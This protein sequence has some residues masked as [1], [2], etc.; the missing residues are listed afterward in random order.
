MEPINNSD[1]AWLIISDYNQDNDL[2]YEELRNDI[3]SPDVND[4]CY[5][6]RSNGVG[7]DVAEVGSYME[8]SLRVG[9]GLFFLDRRSINI[10]EVGGGNDRVG[11]SSIIRGLEVGGNYD[12]SN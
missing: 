2:P 8:Y 10:G 11:S 6:S 5:E 7:F 12:G 3:D 4:W 1:T 9:S